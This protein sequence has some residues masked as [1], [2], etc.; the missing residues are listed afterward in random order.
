VRVGACASAVPAAARPREIATIIS[1]FI[2]YSVG[3]AGGVYRGR[4]RQI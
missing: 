4:A 2:T 3:S 1:F